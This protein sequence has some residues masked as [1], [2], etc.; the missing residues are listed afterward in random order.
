MIQRPKGRGYRSFFNK[1]LTALKPA[2]SLIPYC[3]IPYTPISSL[4]NNLPFVR[5]RRFLGL[6]NLIDAIREGKVDLPA[7]ALEISNCIEIRSFGD[8]PHS[9]RVKHIEYVEV[10]CSAAFKNVFAHGEVKII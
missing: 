3:L 6:L 2:L 4:P 7:P 10:Y 5:S 8:R 1:L 9:A